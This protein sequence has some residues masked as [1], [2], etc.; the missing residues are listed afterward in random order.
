MPGR[1][2]FADRS[3]SGVRIAGASYEDTLSAPGGDPATLLLWTAHRARLA[4]LLDRLKVGRPEPRADRFDPLALRTLL[5][6]MVALLALLAG[7]NLRDRLASAFRLG[8]SIRV[9]D[10]RLDAWVTPAYTARPPLLLRTAPGGDQT[11]QRRQPI[12]FG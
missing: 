11:V 9:A 2:R 4:R 5:M 12:G 10:A 1:E 7:D 6:L 3:A 8:P